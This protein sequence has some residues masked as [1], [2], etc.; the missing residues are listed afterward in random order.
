EIC[1]NALRNK[2]VPVLEENTSFRITYQGGIGTANED[3]LLRTNYNID[4]TGWGSPFLLVPEATNVDD[5][6]LKQLANAQAEDYYLSHASPLG[7]PFN[8]FRKSTGE[9]QRKARIE[10]NR[11]GSACYKKF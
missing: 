1:N 10:K 5:N 3:E 11:P 4:G 6:T 7:I 9:L 2:Q 8:N